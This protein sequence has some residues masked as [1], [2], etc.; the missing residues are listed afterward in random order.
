[1]RPATL[2][3]VDHPN[4]F[5]RHSPIASVLALSL[6]CVGA[7]TTPGTGQAAPPPS[8]RPAVCSFDTTDA[9][10]TIP[11][12]VSL[13]ISQRSD[14]NPRS[15][16]QATN[17]LNALLA[18]YQTPSQ[19]DVQVRP[20]LTI[21]QLGKPPDSIRIGLGGMFYPPIETDGRAAVNSGF[22]AID[23]AL[24]AAAQRLAKE[25]SIPIG[26][27]VKQSKPDPIFLSILVSAGTPS[28]GVP[29]AGAN[30]RFYKADSLVQPIR[31]QRPKYP[32]A[33][34]WR[35]EHARIDL[36][37]IVR[38]DG[39]ADSLSLQIA[40]I[41]VGTRRGAD[42]VAI[43]FARSAADAIL[44]SEYRPTLVRGCPVP[45]QVLQRVSFT[46]GN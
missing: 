38:E 33:M 41:S 17:Y 28:R 3:V 37:Y 35:R 31:M 21:E 15:R 9:T 46:I 39:R 18:Q 44:A 5:N 16:Q 32:Y 8:A 29:I 43:G 1:M 45:M 10:I 30:V 25:R 20:S 6:M 42:P 13:A 27:W 23:E 14:S 36:Q 19:L 40:H 12:V 7:L 34:Q 24:L 11:I 22:P 2:R 4:R 26:D